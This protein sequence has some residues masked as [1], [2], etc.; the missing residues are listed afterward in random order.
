MITYQEGKRQFNYRIVGVALS[1]GRVLLHRS[2]HENFWS[3]PGGRAE[4]LEPARETLRR[5]MREELGIQVEVERLLWVVEN[6]FDYAG[7]SYHELALYFL[8][9]LPNESLWT[10]RREPFFGTENGIR[11]IFKWQPLDELPSVPLYPTF[12]RQGLQTIPDTITH[13]VHRDR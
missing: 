6:F 3:L 5:E 7:K 13:V 10:N 1:E 12:L 4:M 8:M 11:L 2:E 9:T